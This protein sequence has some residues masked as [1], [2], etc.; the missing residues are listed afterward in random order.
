MSGANSTSSRINE[1]RAPGD[2]PR[3]PPGLEIAMRNLANA[4]KGQPSEHK[5]T[6]LE[7]ELVGRR[8]STLSPFVE[9]SLSL[10]KATKASLTTHNNAT[11][12]HDNSK[13]N[14]V[15]NYYAAHNKS[16]S[17][18][19]SNSGN[20]GQQTPDESAIIRVYDQ[21]VSPAAKAG[22]WSLT[23][24]KFLLTLLWSK[25]VAFFVAITVVTV[26]VSLLLSATLDAVSSWVS[27]ATLNFRSI[28]KCLSVVAWLRGY[29]VSPGS[30]S[31]SDVT[32]TI[33]ATLLASTA[34]A[35]VV[36][37]IQAIH[38]SQMKPPFHGASALRGGFDSIRFDVEKLSQQSGHGTTVG[39]LVNTIAV[40]LNDMEDVMSTVRG[41]VTLN[42]DWRV[43]MA[44]HLTSEERAIISLRATLLNYPTP[45]VQEPT[46]GI[47]ISF[48]RCRLL[49]E[50]WSRWWLLWQ[51]P[52]H[53]NRVRR[54]LIA[55]G[56]ILAMARS[57]R[58]PAIDRAGSWPNSDELRRVNH[59]MH[60][61]ADEASREHR[62][63]QKQGGWSCPISAIVNSQVTNEGRN[64]VPFAVKVKNDDE[65]VVAVP[66]DG[67]DA[68]LGQY[69]SNMELSQNLANSGDLLSQLTTEMGEATRRQIGL[70]KDELSWL[71]EEVNRV[72]ELLELLDDG[73]LE[74]RLAEQTILEGL[75]YWDGLKAYLYREPEKGR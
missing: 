21:V 67:D 49:P 2:R 15:F 12:Y 46:K 63:L 31:N 7:S 73:Q 13:N 34:A 10:H 57:H 75:E 29:F 62:R 30:S 44:K 23:I 39:S 4:F 24:L 36:P 60:R 41:L 8:N 25:Y 14:S 11:V 68:A 71:E 59:L 43:T 17:N 33:D 22:Q 20:K 65:D 38:D 27:A 3:R 19:K 58:A 42:R 69:Y 35:S 47:M 32:V 66:A 6:K 61:V 45:D 48:L 55:Y 40:G 64:I 54:R 50:T 53:L 16:S 5:A 74:V 70:V 56:E 1:R 37:V 18:S 51:P 9:K 72:Q 52:Q 28:S 26:S